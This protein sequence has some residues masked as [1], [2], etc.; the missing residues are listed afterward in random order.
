MTRAISLLLA[1]LVLLSGCAPYINPAA[2]NDLKG[3]IKREEY[4]EASNYIEKNKESLYGTDTLQY[5]FDKGLVTHHA[6]RYKES[7]RY[8]DIVE[9]I[10]NKTIREKGSIDWPD[11]YELAYIN[12]FQ[13]LNYLFIG[14][15]DEALVEAR[16]VDHRFKTLSAGTGGSYRGDPFVRYLMGLIYEEAGELNNAYISYGLGLEE[17]KNSKYPVT[18]SI[19]TELEKRYALTGEQL[20]FD[21]KNKKTQKKGTAQNNGELVLIDYNGFVPYKTDEYEVVVLTAVVDGL[22]YNKPGRIA[23]PK[24]VSYPSSISYAV[25]NIVNASSGIRSGTATTFTAQNIENIATKN[26][27]EKI[28]EIRKNAILAANIDFQLQKSLEIEDRKRAAN[29]K[30]YNPFDLSNLWSVLPTIIGVTMARSAVTQGVNYFSADKRSWQTLPREIDIATSAL[31]EGI[32]S[33][34]IDFYDASG[35]LIKTKKIK[36]INVISGHKTFI[37]VRTGL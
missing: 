25:V 35:E 2:Y 12:V 13:A 8:F 3:L 31:P 34:N 19:R 5:W 20:G 7:I 6:G 37:L 21:E 33:A 17:S 28:P 4:N 23:L 9:K 29:N 14:Q 1:L 18:D 16:K 15:T 22:I 26:L 10:V 11:N 32:Y 36:K 27:S 30:N 24:L